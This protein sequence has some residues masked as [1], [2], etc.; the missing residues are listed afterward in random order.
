MGDAALTQQGRELLALFHTGGTH[1]NRLS[2][3]V[4][5]FNVVNYRVQLGLNGLVHQVRLVLAD[6]G[7][8]GG[9]GH[10]ADLVGTSEFCGLGFCR[11]GHA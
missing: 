1:Q 5:L 11:T 6:H 9:D 7:L 3:V 10:D 4:T 8:V 2:G